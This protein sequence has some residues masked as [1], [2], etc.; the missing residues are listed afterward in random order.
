MALRPRPGSDRRLSC[1][2]ALGAALMLLGV[3]AAAPAGAQELGL[4]HGQKSLDAGQYESAVRQLSAT[5]NDRKSNATQIAK[6]LY[7]RGVAYRRMG[8]PARAVSDIGAAVW[9]GLPSSDKAR[10]L[11]NK[12]LAYRAVGL[13]SQANAAIS[14][15]RR[16]SGR[17]DQ[18]LAEESRTAVASVDSGPVSSGPAGESV[19]SRLVPSFGDSSST[20]TAAAP[21]SEPAPEQASQPSQGTATTAAAPPST[22]WNAEVT[23]GAGSSQGNT[24]SRWFGSFAGSNAPAPASSSV[25]S[26]PVPAATTTTASRTT[27]AARTTPPPA[28]P[29]AESWAANTSTQTASDGSTAV[30][31]WFGSL[32]GGSAPTPAPAQP[33]AAP[34]GGGY[35]VQLANSRSRNEAQALW[36]KAKGA[37]APLGSATPRIEQVDIGSFGTFYTV[38][39]GPFASSSESTRVCNAFKRRGTDCSVVAPG[40]P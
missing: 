18:I 11:V 31:R 38:K 20:Q 30:G 21:A 22:G 9:L 39:I 17:V 2:L 36:N 14:Q 35:T 7:L 24:V 6:A 33:A 29:S 25:P 37:N 1:H 28:P 13:S 26:A 5:V 10:A 15:A 27:T 23:E 40:G 32:T 34:A 16:S 4:K 8:Q 3:L 12:G 19:W